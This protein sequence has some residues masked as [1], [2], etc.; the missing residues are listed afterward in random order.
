MAVYGT[1]KNQLSVVYGKNGQELDTVYSAENI[2]LYRRFTIQFL[3]WDG[4]VL[5]SEKLVSGAVPDAPTPERDG[6]VFTG[7]EPAVVAVDGDAV[8]TAVYTA[9]YEP[10]PAVFRFPVCS[11]MHVSQTTT[12]QQNLNVAA[13]LSEYEQGGYD[14]IVCCGDLPEQITGN[15]SEPYS[16]AHELAGQLKNLHAYTITG[17]H[18]C[19]FN[20][21]TVDEEVVA[22]DW[23]EA[24]GCPMYYRVQVPGTDIDMV[25]VAGYRYGASAKYNAQFKTP[26]FPAA[27]IEQ[28]TAW[29]D[30][31]SA[32]GRRVLVFTH[33]CYPVE[34]VTYGY[35]LGYEDTTTPAEQY[36]QYFSSYCAQ[37]DDFMKYLAGCSHILWLSGHVHTAWAYQEEYPHIKA[38]T[39]P[40]GASML[41][42]PSLGYSN[43]DALVELMSDGTVVVRARQGGV[44]LGGQYVYTWDGSTLTKG[45]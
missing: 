28:V 24:T 35:R 45:V 12:S 36:S 18:D 20:N 23:L 10:E 3:D 38:Y 4:T 34:A 44:E 8:Y 22:A 15:S 11:D 43:Q 1:N 2:V 26:I 5:S 31:A 29:L 21:I 30:E 25:F 9:V 6:Y 13:A 40:G 42:L 17:N 33:Y 27:E 14:A 37:D 16:V 41:N 39:I 19:S 7:W 32:A